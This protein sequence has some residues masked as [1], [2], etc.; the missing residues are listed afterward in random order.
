MKR[1]NLMLIAVFVVLIALVAFI[2]KSNKPGP[3]KPGKGNARESVFRITSVVAE[4]NDL[5]S[6]LE[7][8]G[9]VEAD[10]TVVNRPGF[11]GGSFT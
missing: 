3:G 7:I 4:K 10:N 5:H 8:N 9:D 6:Y 11:T 2:P 1:K